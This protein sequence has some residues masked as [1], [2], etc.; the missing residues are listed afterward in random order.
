MNLDRAQV[1]WTLGRFPCEELPELAAQ[2]MV[3]GHEGPSILDLA[4]YHRPTCSDLPADL[5]NQ[6]FRESGRPPLNPE[7]VVLLAAEEL[8]VDCLQ[9]RL[10]VVDLGYRLWSLTGSLE[11]RWGAPLNEVLAWHL[12]GEDASTPAFRRHAEME[13]LKAAGAFLKSRNLAPR[14]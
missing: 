4:S 9:G 14:P 1:D 12:Q 7:A 10:S 5:V 2:M 8:V 11:D 6:A 3:Q 13:L